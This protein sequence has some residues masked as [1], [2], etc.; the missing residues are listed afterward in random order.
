MASKQIRDMGAEDL[1]ARWQAHIERIKSETT[2]L[3]TIRHRWREV[4]RLFSE[5]HELG[6]CG[7]DVYEWLLGMWGRDAIMGIRR[8][9]DDQEGTINLVNMLHEMEARSEVLNRARYLGH[10]RPEDSAFLVRSMNR[11]HDGF[12][13]VSRVGGKRNPDDD[14]IAPERIA[15]DREDLQDKTRTVF[16]Y[17]QRMV[18]HRTPADH[19]ELTVL[20]INEAVDAIEPVLQKYYCILTAKSLLQAEA[21]IQHDWMAPFALVWQPRH[22]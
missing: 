17:A 12:G 3:F 11:D 14:Y 9:L 6:A 10:L 18:A 16:Q 5:N 8:E 1:Y 13:A 19:M 15:A 22:R 20:Q 4:Q 21:A 7:G 2:Y